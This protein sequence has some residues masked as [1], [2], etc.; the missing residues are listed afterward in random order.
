M[1]VCVVY[2][3]DDDGGVGAREGEVRDASAG[4]AWWA[5]FDVGL[6][7]LVGCNLSRGWEVREVGWWTGA[8]EAA[9]YGY[10]WVAA[11]GAE[12]VAEVPVQELT[13]F[14]VDGGWWLCWLVN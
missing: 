12:G 10:G 8:F 7:R 3:C 14:G 11:L 5:G 6:G 1:C 2:D 4:R 9:V 13:S